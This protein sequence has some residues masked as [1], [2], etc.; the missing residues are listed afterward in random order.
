MELR[1]GDAAKTGLPDGSASLVSLSLVIHELAGDARREVLIFFD[2][3]WRFLVLR[4]SVRCFAVV[5]GDRGFTI[6]SLFERRFSF[7]ADAGRAER[8]MRSTSRSICVGRP[9]SALVD[10]LDVDVVLFAAFVNHF[11]LFE[12]GRIRL[13]V[14][15]SKRVSFASFRLF[16]RA[17]YE[18]TLH[19]WFAGAIRASSRNYTEASRYSR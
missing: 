7:G 1:Y 12:A 16:T 17:M 5:G 19:E 13:V 11:V 9:H 4:S 10:E 2:R 15:W 6:V 18:L 3:R 8:S 14:L